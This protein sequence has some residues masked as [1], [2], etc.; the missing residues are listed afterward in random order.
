MEHME[1]D[2]I[3]ATITIGIVEDIVV[4]GIIVEGIIVEDIAV[5]DSVVDIAKLGH[6]NQKI[7]STCGSALWLVRSSW[8]PQA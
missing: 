2:I 5:E 1:A 4:E 7:V 6:S 8:S 3:K